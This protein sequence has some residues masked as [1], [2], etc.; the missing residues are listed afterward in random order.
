[1]GKNSLRHLAGSAPPPSSREGDHE[2][3]EGVA[4][5]LWVVETDSRGRL[6]LQGLCVQGGLPHRFLLPPSSRE[7]DHEVVEGVAAVLWVVD[8]G[9][10]M[11]T[12]TRFA[13]SR[14]IAAPPSQSLNRITDSRG[15]LSL[16]GLC[17]QGGLPHRFLLP[18]SSRGGPRSGG[19][20]RRR[21]AGRGSRTVREASPYK[22]A[23]S[24]RI[25]ARC[26]IGLP[27]RGLFTQA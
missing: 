4:A 25:A 19:R 12:P 16:Q 24:R 3:V 23:C 8:H 27:R 18:P 9:R 6:S 5:A 2:V 10:A 17:V 14:R 20:S 11:R 15:R 7:G 21:V 22:K 26:G 13:C 1:M